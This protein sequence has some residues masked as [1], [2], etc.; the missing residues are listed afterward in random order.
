M[1]F[2][3]YCYNDIKQLHIAVHHNAS[4]LEEAICHEMG[5]NLNLQHA[6]TEG[7]IMNAV[8]PYLDNEVRLGPDDIAGIQALYG[9]PNAQ[10][11]LQ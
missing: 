8:L 2:L 10:V 3:T 11:D 5:H 4:S 7:E 9:A 6:T 1:V